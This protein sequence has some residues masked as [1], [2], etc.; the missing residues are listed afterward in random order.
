M[1]HV[2]ALHQAPK[3]KPCPGRGGEVRGRLGG[4]VSVD[5]RGEVRLVCEQ[6]GPS[7]SRAA[8]QRVALVLREAIDGA[9][10]AL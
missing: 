5:E 4:E 6:G 8:P 7:R 1:L 10:A 2:G 9:V 3:V